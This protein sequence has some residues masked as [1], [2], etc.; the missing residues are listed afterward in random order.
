M[1]KKV[2]LTAVLVSTREGRRGEKVANWFLPIA[3]EDS[4]FEVTLADLKEYDLPFY[5]D[6]VEPS[7]R[8]DKKYPD[9]KVQAWSDVIDGSD[10]IIFIMPEYNHGLSAPLKNAIDH[11]YWEWLEKSVGFVG[12]GSRG[13][14]D[15]IDSLNH[16]TKALKWKVAPTVVGIQR[17]KK[18]YNENGE[19]IED[20]QYRRTAKQMLEQLVNLANSTN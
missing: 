11:L 18:A 13:A 6:E 17:V 1:D 5:A 20:E 10:A 9:P 4:R 16:T 8:E 15:A 19:L 12:Y 14:Q 2:N 7:E 3:Q